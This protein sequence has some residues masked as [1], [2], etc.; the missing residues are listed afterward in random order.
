MRGKKTSIDIKAKVIESKINNPN[1]SSRDIASELGWSVSN[2][3]VCDIINNDLPQVATDSNA[4]ADLVTRNNNL[5]SSADALIAEMIASKDQSITIAQ[6]TSL[7]Q[8]TFTQNQLINGKPTE[9]NKIE[10]VF[11]E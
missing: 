11:K 9:N 1:K 4:V 7:R 10:I 3:T 2:D 5:Q 8:S 6:L